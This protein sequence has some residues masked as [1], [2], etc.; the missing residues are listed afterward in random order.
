MKTVA[1]AQPAGKPWLPFGPFKDAGGGKVGTF[2]GFVRCPA[3]DTIASCDT[4]R[5][6]G[7]FPPSSVGGPP[8]PVT[9]VK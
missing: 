2:A 6:I 5:Q 7:A 3:F 1:P 9:G 4:G 8:A